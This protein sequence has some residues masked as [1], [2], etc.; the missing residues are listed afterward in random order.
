MS[1]AW[2]LE[3]VEGLKQ[4]SGHDD[5]TSVAKNAI[6]Q[7]RQLR[8]Q[9]LNPKTPAQTTAIV[10]ETT[11]PETQTAVTPT[12]NLRIP[13]TRLDRMNN[14]PFD[15]TIDAPAYIAGCTVLA[16]GE[17]VAVLSLNYL[18]ELIAQKQLPTLSKSLPAK[19]PQ[20]VATI[21]IVD[22][23]VAVRRLLDRILNQ[24]GYQVVQCRDGKDALETLNRSGDLYDLVI[25]DIEMPRMDRFTLL[26]EIHSHDRWH[27]LP[28]AMLTSKENDQ[29]RQKARDLGAND[30]FTKPFQ[31]ADLL[32]VIAVLL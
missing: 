32:K 3:K 31:P 4:K 21:L 26:K 7:L 6:T 24:S 8:S 14:T 25:S 12:L 15:A 23:S 19:P 2:L 27:S 28:I 17:V 5:L 11:P 10:E 18:G 13:V 1:L 9:T 16:T 22:D 30:Y 29:H 20:Q